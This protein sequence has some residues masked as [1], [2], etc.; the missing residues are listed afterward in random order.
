MR[1]HG[2][3]MHTCLHA[4]YVLCLKIPDCTLSYPGVFVQTGS[5]KRERIS[6]EG[7]MFIRAYIRDNPRT[8]FTCDNWH[9]STRLHAI[10]L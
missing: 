9:D 6:R 10:T 2:I 5:D 1:V 4:R 3:F 7:L 8:T